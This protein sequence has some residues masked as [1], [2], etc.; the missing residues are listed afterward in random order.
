L[1]LGI[2]IWISFSNRDLWK[3]CSDIFSEVESDVDISYISRGNGLSTL[4]WLLTDT[5]HTM[6]HQQRHIVIKCLSDIL[7]GNWPTNKTTRN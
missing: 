1:H 6:T 7:V 2:S 4:I 3:V 5:G